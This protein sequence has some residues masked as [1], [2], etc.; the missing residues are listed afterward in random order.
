MFTTYQE[1]CDLYVQP[2]RFHVDGEG[3]FVNA[4]LQ[5]ALLITSGY[6]QTP[7]PCNDLCFSGIPKRGVK[8][9]EI[10]LLQSLQSC[11]F[12][13]SLVHIWQNGLPQPGCIHFHQNFAP[14]EQ[15]Q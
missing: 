8:T 5:A 3:R 4:S 1:A 11:S 6:F 9:L 12:C 15:S 2:N 13:G 14:S 10:L 7:F